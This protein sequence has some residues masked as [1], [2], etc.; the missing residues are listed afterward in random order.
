M[1]KRIHP[2]TFPGERSEEEAYGEFSTGE[3]PFERAYHYGDT[4]IEGDKERN[5]L[6][7]PEPG[8][9]LEQED[10]T[11]SH[12]SKGETIT[13]FACPREHKWVY[14]ANTKKIEHPENAA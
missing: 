7:C 14:N 6:M 4:V 9:G 1:A 3:K 5:Y 13:T 2:E 10:I 11:L 12:N 8:C